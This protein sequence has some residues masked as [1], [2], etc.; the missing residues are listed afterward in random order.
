MSIDRTNFLFGEVTY[1]NIL[2]SSD[3]LFY[4]FDE[5]KTWS[6]KNTVRID[7][8]S[9]TK[10]VS[11]FDVTEFSN[12]QLMIPRNHFNI[13]L[14]DIFYHPTL[15]FF[16][17]QLCHLVDESSNCKYHYLDPQ[18][19]KW[20]TSTDF[21]EFVESFETTPFKTFVDGDVRKLNPYTS[22]YF[23]KYMG[24]TF[25]YG[26]HPAI[27]EPY[28]VENVESHFDLDESFS[29]I[30]IGH[31][32]SFEQLI[33][34]SLETHPKLFEV[35]HKDPRS[36]CTAFRFLK[37]FLN[38]I[39][40]VDFRPMSPA[41]ICRCVIAAHRFLCG[42]LIEKLQLIAIFIKSFSNDVQLGDVISSGFRDIMFLEFDPF[43]A[44]DMFLSYLVNGLTETESQHIHLHNSLPIITDLRMKLG[45]LSL[46]S[47]M[48]EVK[49][50]F[51]TDLQFVLPYLPRAEE[52]TFDPLELMF[53][54]IFESI[55]EMSENLSPKSLSIVDSSVEGKPFMFAYI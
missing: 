29:V 41:Q 3:H 42:T 54:T 31:Q 37:N 7:P 12:D 53:G 21:V 33:K 16:A 5:L 28:T 38:L 40:D 11:I 49:Q 14:P 50:F 39:T 4:N 1:R 46:K 18:F 19:Q 51:Q 45:T 30:D 48:V 44:T 15:V 23:V 6:Q 36:K 2:D 43:A 27:F 55:K 17:Q 22:Y 9:V 25:K 26:Y 47:S 8:K 13:A 35:S 32:L 52:I 34:E 20:R 10:T 24:A